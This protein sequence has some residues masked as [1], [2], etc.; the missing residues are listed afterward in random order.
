[1]ITKKVKVTNK[2]GM[3]MRPASIISQNLA[4]FKSEIDIIYL[5]SAYNAKSIMHLMNAPI[6]YGSELTICCNGSDEEQALDW[7]DNFIQSGMGDKE[8]IKGDY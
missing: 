7:L 3:H 1:M 8:E 5:D 4:S 6:K 2:E